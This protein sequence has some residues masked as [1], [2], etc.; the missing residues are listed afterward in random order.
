VAGMPPKE[1]DRVHYPLIDA[2]M[3]SELM[4]TPHMERLELINELLDQEVDSIQD[5]QG[6]KYQLHILKAITL[7]GLEQSSKALLEWETAVDFAEEN[8]PQLDE[9]TI[10]LRVQA[11][12]CSLKCSN[13]NT[14]KAWAKRHAE[15]ALE[16][17]KLLFGGGKERFFKRYQNEFV[18][19]LGSISEA[20]MLVN[21]QAL[22]G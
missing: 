19:L 9:V 20:S 18:C 10:A 22:F 4:A 14:A 1:H 13:R 17:H 11:A 7:D 2:E 16:M 8:F 15:K 5:Y 6:D 12:L 3:Q 21:V